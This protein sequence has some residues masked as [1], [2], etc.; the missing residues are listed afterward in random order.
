[1][2]SPGTQ[3]RFLLSLL[4]V[5]LLWLIRSFVLKAVRDRTED[6]R[7][8]YT[9]QKSSSYVTAAIVL[10][11][12]TILWLES[13]RGLSTFLGLVTAGLAIALKDLVTGL[14]GWVF[15]V[16]RRPFTIGDRIQIGDFRGDVV[17]I[18]VF[19]FSMMEIGNWVDADQSTGRVINI[20]N[21]M[22]IS[23]MLANYS[24]GFQYVWNE[25]PVLIT[26]ESD[27][28]KAKSLLMDIANEHAEHLSEEAQR[29]IVEASKKLMIF[30]RTLTPT[31][32]TSVQDCGVLLTLRYL[33][34]PRERRGT[35]QAIWEDILNC[36]AQYP[37]IDFAYPTQRF[38][39]HRL[40]GRTP[41]ALTP[42]GDTKIDQGPAKGPRRHR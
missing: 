35:E 42:K 13:F 10:L 29:K 16:W 15:I 18:R 24:K 26:F 9:W 7:L 11:F 2:P 33:C 19:Q 17:D 28:R 14:V 36:F 41:G 25:I 12:L 37:E 3:E 6:P 22:V 31:V 38:Y 4:I 1:M 39:D 32:Y 34:K 30:Y 20:P 21:G 5:L 27:W 8:R 40:E 23:H